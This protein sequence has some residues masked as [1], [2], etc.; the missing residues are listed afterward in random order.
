MQPAASRLISVLVAALL[1]VSVALVW[2]GVAGPGL[3][4][5]GVGTDDPF[6]NLVL[7]AYA[8]TTGAV[9]WLGG[10]LSV[11]VAKNPI[12]SILLG[13]GLWLALALFACVALVGFASRDQD[14]E[15][16]RNLAAWLGAWTFVP[17]I[18]LPG[19]VVL[20][21]FPTGRPLTPRW[22]AF[23]WV[24]AIGTVAWALSE[25]SRPFLGLTG[26]PNP[27]FDPRLEWLGDT[28]SLMLVAGLAGAAA[29]II[30]RFKRSRGEERLQLKWITFAGILLIITWGLLWV[31]SEVAPAAFG[32]R[33]I[34]AATLTTALLF[35][36]I[37]AAIL[38]YRL[39]DIDRLISRTISYGLTAG[40]LALIYA[41]VAIALPQL[42]GFGNH[43]ALATAAG[44]LAV[45][46]LF[47][48]VA[49][50][51]HNLVDRRFNRVRFDA[52][53]E[54]KGLAADLGQRLDLSDV[55]GA[56]TSVVQRTVAPTALAVWIKPSR[57]P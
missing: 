51:L 39:Y 15:H 9:A 2:L 45:A 35:V 5:A 23:V 54:V 47:R 41:T 26:L 16:L 52:E 46:G 29:N 7:G 44:T 53:N 50:R 32:G 14:G 30:L 37:G 25:A 6:F 19:V 28:V 17:M 20:V 48:P 4:V 11:K 18:T 33:E 42:F 40:L 10:V 36:A 13:L 55:V 22:C 1:A 27:Y 24:G 8:I 56:M 57:S 21:L 34:A 12:G 49:S 31:V 43:S 38:K 3:S